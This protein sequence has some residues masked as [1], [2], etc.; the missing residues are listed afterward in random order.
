MIELDL[1]NFTF[2]NDTVHLL[3]KVVFLA[4]LAI[5]TIFSLLILRQVTVMNKTLETIMSKPIH[6]LAELHFLASLA[7]LAATLFFF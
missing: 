4:F 2:G 5:Y 6:L 7:V 3:A 1:I